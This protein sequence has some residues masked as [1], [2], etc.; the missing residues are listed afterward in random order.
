MFVILDDGL[1][2]RICPCIGT[3][4]AMGKGIGWTV[5]WSGLLQFWICPSHGE[6]HCHLVF[7][8]PIL[9]CDVGVRH[10]RSG[11]GPSEGMSLSIEDVFV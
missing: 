1:Y 7:H 10:S 11:P 8:L 3:G 5:R 9:R 2:T 4:F 6:K